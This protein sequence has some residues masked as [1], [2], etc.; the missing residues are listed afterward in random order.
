MSLSRDTILITHNYTKV[1]LGTLIDNYGPEVTAKMIPSVYLFNHNYATEGN[2]TKLKNLKNGR[3]LHHLNKLTGTIKVSYKNKPF[4]KALYD[5]LKYIRRQTPSSILLNKVKTIQRY[6]KQ[7]YFN[8]LNHVILI[9]SYM[10]RYY[11]I[12]CKKR[13]LQMIEHSIDF[14]NDSITTEPLYEPYIIIS[15]FE[16]GNFMIYNRL[17]LY[18]FEKYEKIPI[19]SYIQ[20]DTDQ[21]VIVYR[22]KYFYDNNHNK[23]YK[24]PYTRR[25]FTMKDVKNIKHSLIFRFGQSLQNPR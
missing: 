13:A 23:I 2:K 22:N 6:Y 4:R 15:D 24:S 1:H 9:Q 3:P 16:N 19:Y 8:F 12:L 10:R 14:C 7:R 5:D 21:E 11:V 17:T 18:K 25:E 20:A